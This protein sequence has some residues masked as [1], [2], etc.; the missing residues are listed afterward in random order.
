MKKILIFLLLFFGLKA[1]AQSY[2]CRQ[3]FY[4]PDIK[5]E[6]TIE[7]TANFTI[8]LILDKDSLL[9][10]NNSLKDTAFIKIISPEIDEGV[11]EVGSFEAIMNGNLIIFQIARRRGVP[12][13]IGIGRNDEYFVFKFKEQN[14]L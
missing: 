4:R 14:E 8:E 6:H 11:E 13:G 3:V 7:D 12:V 5:S 9:I 10:I 1:G 2:E